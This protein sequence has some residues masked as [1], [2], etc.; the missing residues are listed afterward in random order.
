MPCARALIHHMCPEHRQ[1]PDVVF[2]LQKVTDREI[3]SLHPQT[4]S[5]GGDS[6]LH[7]LLSSMAAPALFS[8]EQVEKTYSLA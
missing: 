4:L 3:H 1:A 2:G 8:K 7:V 5:L 6:Q